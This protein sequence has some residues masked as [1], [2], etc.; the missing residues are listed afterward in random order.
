MSSG[1]LE[2][3][4]GALSETLRID[5]P[6]APLALS[7]L[8]RLEDFRAEVVPMGGKRYQIL[9]EL[10][11]VPGAND[12]V[13]EAL[14]RIE[15]WIETSELNLADVHLNGRPY[16]RAS[17]DRPPSALAPPPESVGVVC[18][19]KTIA[20]GAGVQVVSAEGELDLHATPQ[21]EELLR[22]TDSEHVILDLTEAVFV[23]STT[24]SMIVGTANRMGEEGRRLSI[25][26]GN[27]T[28]ARLFK[29]TGL[30]RVLDVHETLVE[31]IETALDT[32]VE[33]EAH[34]RDDS[35]R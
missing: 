2:S 15:G 5:L 31:A 28:V 6:T 30:D 13:R 18:R 11:G 21:L 10:D 4:G 33:V 24:V 12:R 16:R 1:D 8:E 29:I 32:A 26:A 3:S 35:A 27:P 22:S 23:D 7:L 17:S 19:V 9:V 20:L 14:A 34:R 25:V